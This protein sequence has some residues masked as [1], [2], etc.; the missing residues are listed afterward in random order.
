MLGSLFDWNCFSC[1]PEQN[2]E[3]DL[4][5]DEQGPTPG[6]IKKSSSSDVELKS[7]GSKTVIDQHA[8]MLRNHALK[9]SRKREPK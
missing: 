6:I 1:K 4:N 5:F 3:H 7:K 8:K 9:Q 2:K